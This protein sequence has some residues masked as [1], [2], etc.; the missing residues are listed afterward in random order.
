MKGYVSQGDVTTVTGPTLTTYRAYAIKWI[1]TDDLAFRT[2]LTILILLVV[3]LNVFIFFL[4]LGT[5]ETVYDAVFKNIRHKRNP[6]YPIFW[7]VVILSIGW[8]IWPGWAV[9]TINVSG[10]HYFIPT[11]VFLQFFT[12]LVMRKYLEF[13]IPGLRWKSPPHKFFKSKKPEPLPPK[14]F[15]WQICQTPQVGRG[16]I[17]FIV[18]TAAVWSLLVLFTLIVYYAVTIAVALYLDP[19]QTLV[20]LLFVKAI[21]M[22]AM[23]A[24]ALLFASNSLEWKCTQKSCYINFIV[25]TQFLSALTFLP[26]LAYLAY[27]IGG[28]IF[29]ASSTQLSGI[30]GVLAIL[31]SAF[32]III[33]WVSHGQLFPEKIVP[34]DSMAEVSKDVQEAASHSEDVDG[35][36][37]KTDTDQ[38]PGYGTM[39]VQQNGN[40][41]DQDLLLPSSKAV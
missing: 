39:D 22:C 26:V 1:S 28:V 29:V 18:Q 35:D 12:A 19:I 38:H 41:N 9:L 6:Y 20:K 16:V 36:S 32:L 8:N 33:G 34:T 37:T 10:L 40:G 27:M 11:I 23:F 5:S 13:P 2:G 14:Y 24:V 15:F 21:A 25:V 31:P 7:S 3:V 30:Q 4:S 17:S